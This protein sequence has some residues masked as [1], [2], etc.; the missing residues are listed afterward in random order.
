MLVKTRIAWDVL[1]LMFFCVMVFF[2]FRFNNAGNNTGVH[3]Q[4]G[5][6]RED[7]NTIGR[8]YHICSRQLL[9]H[10]NFS[11]ESPESGFPPSERVR[12]VNN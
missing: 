5:R 6:T 10:P 7:H 8:E 3:V 9:L 1:V 2:H 12:L 11:V 4:F